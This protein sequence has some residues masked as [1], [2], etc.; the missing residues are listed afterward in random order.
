MCVC[1]HDSVGSVFPH[2]QSIHMH[3]WFCTVISD[4]D[5]SGHVF[6][7]DDN[8]FPLCYCT[9]FCVVIFVEGRLGMMVCKHL[10]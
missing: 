8:A 4:H 2:I 7:F 10:E 1:A 9:F 3:M 5:L 6:L